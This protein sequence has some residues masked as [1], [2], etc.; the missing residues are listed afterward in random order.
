LAQLARW[1]IAE[2]E[3]D[4]VLKLITREDASGKD[5]LF[6][7][8][9]EALVR[10]KSW[11][12]LKDFLVTSKSLPTSQINVL[13][14][15]ARC[16]NASKEPPAVVMDFLTQARQ[17]AAKAADFNSLEFLAGTAASMGFAEISIDCL[18]ATS[19]STPA[20]WEKNLEQILSLQRTI[21]D[22][23]AMLGTLNELKGLKKSSTPHFDAYVYLKLISGIELETVMDECAIFV[24]HGNI[25]PDKYAFFKALAAYRHDDM[26][27]LKS[28]LQKVNPKKLPLN[29]RAVCAGMLGYTGD[30]ALAFQLSE[31]IAVNTLSEDERNIFKDA[32]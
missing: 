12:E 14:L 7:C 8:Y 16:A 22:I 20:R 11:T 4:Q 28:S 1:L 23:P 17:L 27:S 26:I 5:I 21:G 9:V 29:W 10:K 32:L 31:K 6:E 25:S 15:R 30:R 24:E 18:R 3:Y 13:Q 19:L 2:S